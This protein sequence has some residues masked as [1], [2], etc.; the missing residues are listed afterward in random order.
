MKKSFLKA[1]ALTTVAAMLPT[2]L[3]CSCKEDDTGS[4]DLYQDENYII[5][6]DPEDLEWKADTTP[7]TMTVY[8]NG[9]NTQE[10]NWGNDYVSKEITKRTGV[11]IKGTYA[12]DAT[13]NKLALMLSSGEKLPDFITNVATHSAIAKQMVRDKSILSL[14]DL[15]DQYAPNTRQVLFKGEE[16]ICADEDG[17]LYFFS[18]DSNPVDPELNSKYVNFYGN[19]CV[20]QDI[21]DELGNPE[22]NT[23][24]Q[25]LEVLRTVKRMYS[26]KIDYPI[27]LPT[28]ALIFMAYPIYHCFGGTVSTTDFNTYYDPEKKAVYY[29]YEDEIGKESLKFINTLYREKLLRQEFVLDD[30]AWTEGRVFIYGHPNIGAIG[31]VNKILQDAGSSARYKAIIPPCVE[32]KSYQMT[33]TLSPDTGWGTCIT[34][35][36]KDPA[37]AIKYVQFMLSDEGQSLMYFGKEGIDYDVETV[38]GRNLPK[39][40]GPI[41]ESEKNGTELSEPTGL[42]SYNMYNW[43]NNA[44]F[45]F[46]NLL[47][48]GISDDSIS[49]QTGYEASQVSKQ[50]TVFNSKK[51]TSCAVAKIDPDSEAG[52]ISTECAKIVATALPK[53]MFA[54]SD[55]E[56]ETLYANMLSE[57]KKKGMETY[58]RE[59]TR[60][61]EEFIK[62]CEEAGMQF[63]D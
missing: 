47:G 25:M 24:Q 55:E 3:L 35:D 8:Y 5:Q 29:W 49:A 40:K 31:A 1:L 10:W 48:K 12:P 36:A 2:L 14:T 44:L 62:Q 11:T 60:V 7:I 18:K 22:M 15:M 27:T 20:R 43:R 13:G 53:I 32:G 23:P 19:M 59:A 28:D 56:F 63:I 41:F 45:Q 42:N 57:M 6:K 52:K 51:S 58:R 54:E 4:S 16:T 34:K 39:F 30:T 37:R 38:D 21:M 9:P 26:D 46:A 50:Y 33:A 61:T 17:K